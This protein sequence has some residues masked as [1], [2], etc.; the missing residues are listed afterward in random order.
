MPILFQCPVCQERYSVPE[1]MVGAT[2]NCQCCQANGS[3][4]EPTYVA[5]NQ[6]VATP[7][8]IQ[9]R[10]CDEDLAEFATHVFSEGELAAALNGLPE[11]SASAA[12]GSSGIASLMHGTLNSLIGSGSVAAFWAGV[13]L[14]IQMEIGWMAWGLGALSGF[15]MACRHENNHSTLAGV[16]ATVMSL[17]GISVAKVAVFF[18]VLLPILRQ[19]DPDVV[20]T[21]TSTLF[22]STMFDPVDGVFIFLGVATAFKVGCGASGED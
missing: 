14:A 9:D 1:A 12:A 8:P 22:F 11:A 10:L 4:A 20:V 17:V 5:P 13:A 18:A 21:A 6:F 3:L 7:I 15:G 16:I 19:I 2:T